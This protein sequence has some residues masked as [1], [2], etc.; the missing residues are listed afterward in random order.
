MS[1]G[2]RGILQLNKKA[3]SRRIPM[4][5]NWRKLTYCGDYILIYWASIAEFV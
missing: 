4:S 3:N 5:S 2:D 1:L